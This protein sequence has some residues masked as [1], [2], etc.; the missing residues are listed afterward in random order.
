MANQLTRID[1]FNEMLR[2]DPFRGMDELLRDLPLRTAATLG[3]L[4]SVATPAIRMDVTETDRNFLVKAEIP[5]VN[6]E[7]IKVSVDGRQVT[8]SAEIERET[9]LK[10]GETMI[11]SE[12]YRG[13]QY[14]SFMLANDI[15]DAEVT[16][17][18]NNGMLN[19]TLPKKTSSSVKKIAIR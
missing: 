18:Y 7:D 1:P 8:I 15:N 17:E 16:A 4:G 11:R 6:K 19:L 12:R 14:R 5:G 9:E 3:G 13:Q 10:E 2:F